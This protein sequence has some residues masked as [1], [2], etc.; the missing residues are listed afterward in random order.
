MKKNFTFQKEVYSQI[1]KNLKGNFKNKNI[2]VVSDKITVISTTMFLPYYFKSVKPFKLSFDTKIK[3]LQNDDK[4]SVSFHLNIKKYLVFITL[5][6]LVIIILSHFL[7]KGILVIFIPL[8]LL[9]V[10]NVYKKINSEMEN[11]ISTLTS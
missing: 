3:V 7:N 4:T 1:L 5:F 8:F 6:S 11:I 10:S 9:Y 2:E